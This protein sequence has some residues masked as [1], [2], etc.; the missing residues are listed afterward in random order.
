MSVADKLT[1]LSNNITSAYTSISTMNGTIPTYKNTQNIANAIL[2]I[3]QYNPLT[4]AYISYGSAATA[5]NFVNL[6]VGNGTI[7]VGGASYAFAETSGLTSLDLS[8]INFSATTDTICMFNNATDLTGITWADSVDFSNVES[9]QGM[10]RNTEALALV[11]LSA[12]E[13]GE[14][15]ESVFNMFAGSGVQAVNLGGNFDT[16]AV[17]DFYGMFNSCE[18][19]TDLYRI[20]NLRMGS[21]QDLR[22]M[23]HGCSAMTELDLGEGNRGKSKNLLKPLM[24]SRTYADVEYTYNSDGSLSVSGT[25]NGISYATST[26]L[27]IESGNMTT[28]KAGTYTLSVIGNNSLPVRLDSS[29]GTSITNTTS[30]TTF[31]LA[32]EETVYLTMRIGSGFVVPNGTRIY[33]Q[34]EL[35]STATD[36]M[37]YAPYQLLT[38]QGMATPTT[39]TG[40]WRNITA[41]SFTPGSNGWGSFYGTGTGYL[42]MFIK[43]EATGMEAGTD[44]TMIFEVAEQSGNP[45]LTINDTGATTILASCTNIYAEPESGGW[46]GYGWAACV[47]GYYVV[48]A[49]T[50]SG[51]D[52]DT[53][54]V[55]RLFMG[56]ASGRGAKIRLTILKGDHSTDWQNYAW[57]PYA[58]TP[59]SLSLSAANSD[60]MLA[61][62]TSLQSLNLSGW[63]S[64]SDDLANS[65]FWGTVKNLLPLV[66]VPGGNYGITATYDEAT[67]LVGLTGTGNESWSNPFDTTDSSIPAGTYTF[68]ISQAINLRII[69]RLRIDGNNVDYQI[70]IGETSVTFTTTETATVYRVYLASTKNTVVNWSGYIQLEAGSS[71]SSFEPYGHTANLHKLN[72]SGPKRL[73]SGK[74]ADSLVATFNSKQGATITNLTMNDPEFF[75]TDG[76]T[77]T[78]TDFSDVWSGSALTTL[79]MTGWDVSSV[80]PTDNSAT[81]TLT[82][83]ANLTTLTIGDWTTHASGVNLATL[84]GVDNNG[85]NGYSGAA[86]SLTNLHITG[87]SVLKVY[88]GGA[89][90]FKSEN[91]F[92]GCPIGNGTGHIYVPSSLVSS[93]QADSFWSAYSSIITAES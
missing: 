14:Y 5:Q 57:Q 33:A 42:D 40:F 60:Y 77:A 89:G 46:A 43:K 86:T 7:P 80:D 76:T 22:A 92:V 27:A 74:I 64:G 47:N 52:F 48:K 41:A 8:G 49:T 45:Y 37:P 72:L 19:L 78:L 75:T 88:N 17:T 63:K 36:Y 32:A 70:G 51:T 25:A 55:L 81:V 69:L 18:N 1:T 90:E 10:Y 12:F 29:S 3:P 4:L 66:V 79:E 26:S 35:G 30:T 84:L 62:M 31:T 54:T 56:G 16:S 38:A 6:M 73:V 20:N 82:S 50:K 71:T 23:F 44:Y 87:N 13:T 67:G 91:A 11:D 15:L 53:A 21:A 2:T 83:V 68:S 39:D 24:V 85:S 34:V 61:G 9:M 58:F 93:Y 28:L 59:P 65:H